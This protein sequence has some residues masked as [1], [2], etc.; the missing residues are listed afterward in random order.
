MSAAGEFKAA[1]D[2]VRKL[3]I[4]ECVSV[5]A[6]GARAQLIDLVGDDAG[7]R[8][9]AMA[10]FLYF[11]TK[12]CRDPNAMVGIVSALRAQLEAEADAHV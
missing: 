10:A 9:T 12:D 5:L 7:M 11:V 6:R 8:L 4:E 1:P 3:S 2:Q